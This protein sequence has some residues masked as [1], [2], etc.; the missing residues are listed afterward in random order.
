MHLNQLWVFYHVAKHKSFSLAAGALCLSQPSVSNQIKFME[1]SYGLK[2]FERFGRN[3]GLTS[4]GEV[5]YT[6]AEQIFKLTKEADSVI[7]EIRGM[8]SG[9]IKISAS[10]TLGAYYLPDI[11]DLFKKK[12]PM[13]EIQMNVG[14]TQMVVESILTFKSDLG[15]IGQSVTHPNIVAIP[16]WD[17][18][19]VLIVPPNHPFTRCPSVSISQLRD[20]PF[21]MSEKGSGVRS[22]TDE[23][24]SGKGPS[25]RIIMEL[26]ENEAIKH[27]VA[28]GLGITIISAMVARRELEAG[29]LKAARLSGARIMRQFFIIHH[30]DKYLSDLI[31]AFM[32]EA[33]RFSVTG[34]RTVPE[35][36]PPARI[37]KRPSP[38]SSDPG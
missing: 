20:Q 37:R 21:I 24:L 27:A 23:I 7:K 31:R 14:Y 30:S 10:H 29:V 15:L 26:G 35:G 22:I 19:L 11:I 17:E 28:S 16:L 9:G 38:G 6:Y 5:L 3:I 32:D 8:K 2:L 25:P 33:L 4:T 34:N 12:Y 1:D 18:E 13:V 36:K